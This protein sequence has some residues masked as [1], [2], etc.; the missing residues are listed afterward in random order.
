MKKS[1]AIIVSL[2]LV[3]WCGYFTYENR[4]QFYPILE[5]KAYWITSLVLVSFFYIWAQGLILKYVLEPYKIK[6]KF[7]EWFGILVVTL[8]GNYIFPFAGIGFRATYLKKNHNLQVGDFIASTVAIYWWEFL[9]FAFGGIVGLSLLQTDTTVDKW[10]L[11]PV[12]VSGIT[13]LFIIY[14]LKFR[15]PLIGPKKMIIKVNSMLESWDGIKKDRAMMSK[16]GLSTTLVFV[17]YTIM[18]AIAYEAF[19][20]IVPIAGN[21]IVACLSDYSFFIRLA[22]AAFGSYEASIVYSSQ[23]YNLTLAE[24]LMVAGLVRVAMMICYF[25]LGPIYSYVLLGTFSKKALSEATK[26]AT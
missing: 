2:L 20:F 23:L 13:F 24:G 5:L 11:L 26:A 10:V 8:F 9:I 21:M 19:G 12:L 16:V 14:F 4:E 17:L 18:F 3:V 1:I 22:P 7:K 25:S 6:L 15:F